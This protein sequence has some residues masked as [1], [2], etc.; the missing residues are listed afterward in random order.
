M[1]K[2]AAFIVTL[3]LAISH[4]QAQCPFFTKI[5]TSYN[6][7]HFLG[8]KN[9]GTLWA[10]GYNGMGQLGDGS[11]TNRATPVQVGTATNWVDFAVGAYHSLGIKS[12]G[13]LWAWGFNAWSSLGDGTNTD[14]HSPV[15]IGSATNWQSVSAGDVHSFAI[16]TTGKLYAW[17]YNGDGELG[18]GNFTTSNTPVAITP[19]LNWKA[20][21]GGKYHSMGITDDDKLWTWGANA[22][23]QL[24][25]GTT[26]TSNIPVTITPATNWAVINCGYDISHAITTDGRLFAWG[27]NDY[28]QMG[29]GTSGAGTNLLVPSQVGTGTNWKDVS[30][31]WDHTNALTTD[32]KAWAW[33]QNIGSQFGNGTNT[34]SLI[35][36][37]TAVA[38]TFK[39]IHAGTYYSA[40]ITTDDQA[41]GWGSHT[42]Y[43]LAG[44]AIGINSIPN[45]IANPQTYSGL[46]VTGTISNRQQTTLTYYDAG[47][48]R[49]IA[50]VAQTNA[51]SIVGNT[52]GR[53]WI[54]ATQPEEYVRRHFE[55]WPASNGSTATGRV[56]LYVTQA[57]LDDF[58]YQVPAPPLHMPLNSSDA[59]GK[60]IV[61]IEKREGM[62]N[63]NTGVPG[64]YT[65]TVTTIDP[66]D[67]DIVWN[68]TDGRWEI[69]FNV[70]GFGG[71]F[72]KPQYIAILPV[73]WININGT[74]NLQKEPFIQWMVDEPQLPGYEIEKSIDGTHFTTAAFVKS[75]GEGLN[76]YTYNEKEW[77]RNTVYYR[78]KA[79]GKTGV[80]AYSAVVK[81]TDAD[82]A[83]IVLYPN[84]VKTTA[85]LHGNI[86]LL[87]TKAVL[88]DISGKTIAQF[89]ISS[90]PYSINL[91]NV[92]KGIYLLKTADGKCL[93]FCK[94]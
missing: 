36:L 90:L 64:S 76:S 70:T 58:S 51:A 28:G 61:R 44:S 89:N 71:L 73:K 40:G 25:N 55:I 92:S 9:D 10:W 20:V 82:A 6:G 21:K 48:N 56:T 4:L 41:L 46:D 19:A 11:I 29:N 22:F 42:T 14:R 63:D 91:Q 93:K 94:D 2:T 8:I 52:A 57:E 26:V 43:Y 13:T 85:V 62:S 5:G 37:A 78:I 84:P 38:Y 77:L 31:G 39:N 65:G 74:V 54:E 17:G 87:N 45:T 69:S 49:L 24:G 86:S 66:D 16:T 35:P 67:A 27:Q 88:T 50:S 72:I 33:G 18:T 7:H 53:L 60:A 79:S 15:Q 3:F 75:K 81:L 1:K 68:N 47:C 34:P 59:V 83:A 12:D 30:V 80:A 32:G 23:G